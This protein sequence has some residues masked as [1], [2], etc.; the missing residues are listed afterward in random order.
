VR[1]YKAV[2]RAT[3]PA[4]V[5]FLCLLMAM[6]TLFT[7]A[8][9]QG[10]SALATSK[11]FTFDGFDHLQSLFELPFDK[12]P[13]LLDLLDTRVCELPGSG[14]LASTLRAFGPNKETFFSPMF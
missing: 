6:L 13:V 9:Q 1:T 10:L 14:D 12:R 4:V 11:G 8:E 5:T 7:L 2:E 3:K